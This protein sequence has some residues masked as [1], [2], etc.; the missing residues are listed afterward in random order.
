M[1]DPIRVII[2]GGIALAVAVLWAAFLVFAVTHW[3]L[4]VLLPVGGIALVLTAVLLVIED[5]KQS[6]EIHAEW[7]KRRLG[8]HRP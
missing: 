4:S 2:W 5:M 7:I 6:E 1:M 8:G 3:K